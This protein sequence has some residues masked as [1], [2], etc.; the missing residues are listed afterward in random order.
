M[1]LDFCIPKVP[2]PLLSKEEKEKIDKEIK[3]FA[4][5]YTFP[6]VKMVSENL[7]QDNALENRINEI[8]NNGGKL[9]KT[10]KTDGNNFCREINNEILK[11]VKEKHFSVKD[12]CY[13]IQDKNIIAAILFEEKK[14]YQNNIEETEEFKIILN[15]AYCLVEKI[16]ENQKKEFNLRWSTHFNTMRLDI[17]YYTIEFIKKLL[18]S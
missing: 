9:F 10:K 13:D 18:Q 16:I 5:N 17:E 12:F 4:K 8:I 3:E 11:Y 14:S 6:E 7:Y 2:S 1:E 15:S